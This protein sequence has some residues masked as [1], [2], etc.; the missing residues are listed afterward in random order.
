M[1]ATLAKFIDWTSIQF[2]WAPLAIR[3]KF[4][5]TPRANGPCAPLNETLRLEQA[6]EFLTG[7]DFIPAETRPAQVEFIPD[8]SGV[9]FCFQT[10][11][12]GEVEENNIV[13]G[14]I[15]PTTESWLAR[16]AIVLM[17]GAPGS[18]YLS[19]FSIFP[20][21]CNRAG[22]NVI[23]LEPPYRFRRR[24]KHPGAQH[25]KGYL[26]STEAMAQ[27]IAEIRALVGWLKGEGCPAVALYGMSY[28]G[29]LAGLV[30]LVTLVWTPSF[31]IYPKC[32]RKCRAKELSGV[33][34]GKQ[35]G[36]E[37]GFSTKAKRLL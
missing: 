7:S 10:P 32:I 8:G 30:A 14:R 36:R 23:T 24:P 27:T 29:W 11:R 16:P 17:P 3:L 35:C 18:E 6:L 20:R 21:R 9:N 4:M 1:I 31:S 25:A 22:F 5:R 37:R 33:A 2:I 12:P 13:Y 19:P 26:G 34:S 28:G 15:Y